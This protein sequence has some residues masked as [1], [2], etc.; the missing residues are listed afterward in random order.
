MDNTLNGFVNHHRPGRRGRSAPE[1]ARCLPA[2]ARTLSG[3]FVARDKHFHSWN[4]VVAGGPGTPI[5]ATPL[6]V[7]LAKTTQTSVAGEPFTIDRRP[8]N[9]AA[10]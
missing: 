9:R 3:T 1:H 5:A 4:L 2:P 8:G 7:A 6:T 10:T